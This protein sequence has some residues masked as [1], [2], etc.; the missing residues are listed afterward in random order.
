[1]R[2]RKGGWKDGTEQGLCSCLVDDKRKCIGK[3]SSYG[4][5]NEEF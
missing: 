2:K 1:M 4:E 5:W 3:K